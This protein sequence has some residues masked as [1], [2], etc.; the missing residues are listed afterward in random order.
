MGVDKGSV[1]AVVGD[2]G[3]SASIAASGGGANGMQR[4]AGLTVGSGACT[5]DVPRG[6]YGVCGT[7]IW[8][9]CC[10]CLST[11]SNT[12]DGGCGSR[13]FLLAFVWAKGSFFPKFYK[14][15]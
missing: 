4:T 11:S 5:G 1:V 9:C 3:A 7:T 2:G 14:N 15:N 6:G 8:G 10:C 12:W 13:G